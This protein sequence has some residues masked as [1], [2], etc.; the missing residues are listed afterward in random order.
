MNPIRFWLLAGIL[1]FTDPA[2]ARQSPVV[3]NEFLASNVSVNPDMVDFDDFSDWIELYNPGETAA[4][5]SG[6]YLTDNLSDPF[7]WELPE[8]TVIDAGGYLLIWAD[9]YDD[10]PGNMHTRPWW[11]F[12][13]TF[14]TQ[15]LHT[16]FKLS[17]SGE[18]I[19]L[20]NPDGAFTDTL[21]YERQLQDVSFGRY[22]DGGS[23]WYRF[24]E[25]SPESSNTPPALN[26]TFSAEAVRFSEE[27][28]FYSGSLTVE[29]SVPRS[30][31]NH[32]IRYTLDGS[33][34]DSESKLYTG[35]I[36]VTENT[37]ISARSYSDGKLPGPVLSHS[38]LINE[39]RNLPAFSLITDPDYFMGR[40][41]GIYRNTLKQREIPANLEFFPVSDNPTLNMLTGLRIG[42]ENIFRFAQK[43]L[44]IYADGSYGESL[45]EYPL[46]DHL[47]YNAFKRLFL[48]NSGDDWPKTMFRDG[49]MATLLLNEFDNATQAY[50]PAVV[51]INGDYWGIYNLREKIDDQYFSQHFNTGIA[52]LDHIE[53][54]YKVIT[55]DS[56]DYVNLIQFA[57][58][59]D[60]SVQSN[61]N[62]MKS[63]MDMD[64][65]MDFII[66]SSYIVN[67]SWHH[68]IE[69]WRDR[70]GDNLWKWVI[71]DM[72]RG[73]NNSL[74]DR[75]QLQ[76]IYE[77]YSLFRNLSD[78]TEFRDTFV[79]RYA[80]R[81]QGAFNSER[82]IQVI[83]SLQAGIADEI[84]RH[85]SKWG[86]Y[87]DSLS[88]D[89]WGEE[90]GIPSV[91]EWNKN[92]ERF[93]DFATNRPQ[94][95]LQQLSDLYGLDSLATLRLM[96]DAGVPVRVDING[97]RKESGDRLTYFRDIPL[98]L[99]VLDP[100]GYT[101][102]G[103][104]L[105]S[106]GEGETT[107]IPK[108]SV[109]KYFYERS[110]P[111]GNWKTGSFDDS[112]WASGNGP[113]GYGDGQTTVLDFGTDAEDK[114]ITAYFRKAFTVQNPDKYEEIKLFVLRDDAIVI[115]LNGTEVI[116]NNLPDGEITFDTRATDWVGGSEESMYVEFSIS[117]ASL[118]SGEN[119][120]AAEVHQA[121]PASSDLSFDLQLTGIHDP[122][123][124][125]V[126]T[127]FISASRQITFTPSSNSDLILSFSNSG[128][129]RLPSAISGSVSLNAGSSPYYMPV[130]MTVAEGATLTI[131][132]GV[133][134]L[135]EEETAI[136]VQGRLLINGTESQPVVIRPYYNDLPWTGIILENT[137]AA[138]QL[139]HLH[140]T[141]AEGLSDHE[142]YFS[143][144][145]LYNADAEI[146]G[147]RM[148]NVPSAISSQFSN[149]R[150]SNSTIAGVTKIGDYLNVNGGNLW[151]T[152]S[153]FIG[154]NV[155]DMDA[156][157]IGYM[158]DSTLI[159][160]NRFLNF[161]GSNSD[162]IDV[163]DQ[164][165]NVQITGNL[166]AG[167]GDKGVSIGQGSEAY[168]QA[169]IIAECGTG[170][171]IKDSSST[172]YIDH[173]TFYGNGAGVHAFEKKL[174]R[175]GGR[176]VIT[177]SVFSEST[178][179]SVLADEYSDINISWSFSDTDSLPGT[180]NRYGEAGLVN[181]RHG[182]YNPQAVSAIINA[183]NPDT[184][185]S[186]PWSINEAGAVPFL[187][188]KFHSVVI[189]EINYNAHPDA[190]SDDWLELYNN[191]PKAV[192][193]SGWILIDGSYDQSLIFEEGKM[194][195]GRSYMV[196]S[197]NHE[198]F[199]S[200]F[201]DTDLY[202]EPMLKGFSGGGESLFL[203]TG[204]GFL[205]DSLTYD[206]T[207]PW[208]SEP[209]G[210][211]PTLELIH[212]DMDNSDPASWMAS[213]G[214]GSPG[215]RNSATATDNETDNILPD[216]YHL[217]QN[218]PNPFNPS[219]VIG[220]DLPSVSKVTLDV[221]D[222][223]G[224]KV[225]SLINRKMEA[226]RHTV[227][228]RAH[229]LSSG[230]YFYRMRAGDFIQ[231]RKFTLLK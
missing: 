26:T 217:A 25:P 159:S 179:A 212:P 95:A 109:W 171:G 194:L 150:I 193:L 135:A 143:A 216:S 76:M 161:A 22:P 58:E 6:Y 85:I 110:A 137:S 67:G 17:K 92:V 89:V 34:P 147:L 214:N 7:K 198:K 47:P 94:F 207:L 167:C 190:D 24:G 136:R 31:G 118:I 116:R 9:G 4:D 101:F 196:I 114:P 187:G 123:K 45:I 160:G 222:I 213:A 37:V 59:Q 177:N 130:S 178:E 29:L 140:I 35:P 63:V 157:D 5:I 115:Y 133:Q 13:F 64:S 204:D 69:T 139:N 145:S 192:D 218:Y 195:G 97:F 27:G 188:A 226:G 16:N 129:S 230:V 3:I 165:V 44:N 93:R 127:T 18:E 180:G 108:E 144:I 51:Y 82:V 48:R 81:I 223:L 50:R 98:N 15:R 173:S 55:G 185:N 43:P 33:R 155:D 164:S 107:V 168:I 39:S 62:Y 61:Y 197:R 91:G 125:D 142:H 182:L 78:N 100:P 151:L 128:G 169:T 148:E 172:A 1:L 53:S 84:P 152:G 79:T 141:G 68:N 77:E 126:D 227:T 66:V 60:L 54:S 52:D 90:S 28:G 202:V 124:A 42:G 122:S 149:L 224:R 162:I 175:G 36:T 40:E 209:D 220:F 70:G 106:P 41:L 229:G 104:S 205:T 19:G 32:E 21:V 74:A 176:A 208:P 138:S 225:S 86:T 153:E 184:R 80:E 228:F 99:E 191:S 46:Y 30:S 200:I 2:L 11:P 56:T 65:F 146:N 14:T 71:V 156:I 113:L 211:G 186:S 206:D 189:N 96:T 87:I 131:G 119:L 75:D 111:S 203:Y 215:E 183:S 102:S 112:E 174:N 132:K 8:G 134:I 158:K 20:A 57:E 154:N 199:S 181:P 163:G 121:T 72:D 117:P 88:L 12:S 73:F 23:E 83:D 170:V 120:L 49:L 221:F 219:T 231:T 201:E 38:Y 105:T 10:H 103:W 210:T 166:L